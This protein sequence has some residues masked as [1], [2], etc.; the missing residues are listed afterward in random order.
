MTKSVLALVV[1]VAA[2][3]SSAALAAPTA[4][5]ITN[6]KAPAATT[7]SEMVVAQNEDNKGVRDWGQGSGRDGAGQGKGQGKKGQ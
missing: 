5:S 1:I 4:G 7:E 6:A 2:G 3:F